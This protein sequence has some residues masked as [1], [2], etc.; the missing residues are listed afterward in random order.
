MSD[1]IPAQEISP[2]KLF[3]VLQREYLICI[4]RAKIYPLIKHKNYWTDLANKK[5]EKICHLKAKHNLYSIFDDNNIL[6]DYEK[7]T[8]NDF[9][10]PNF[11]YPNEK[12][13]DQQKYWDIRNYF[14]SGKKVKFIDINDNY[15]LK[16]GIIRYI[17]FERE[18]VIVELIEKSIELSFG[19]VSRIL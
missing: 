19:E 12:V 16:E 7:K 15:K 5:K 10:L 14:S 17:Q 18:F 1:F 4:L 6:K 11:Y 2:H 8:Y 3:D 13:M 9:G